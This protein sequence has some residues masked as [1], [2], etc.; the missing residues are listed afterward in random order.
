MFR[1]NSQFACCVALSAAIALGQDATAER[2]SAPLTIQTAVELAGRNYPAIRASLA[3]VAAAQSGVDLAKTAYLPRTD[4]RLGVNRA[5]RNNV[6][7]LILPNAVIPA[8]SG[9]VQDDATITSTFGSSAGVLFSYEPFDFGLRRSNV[10]VA[11][12]LQARAEAGRAVTEYEISL[13][14]AD[15]YLQAAA[16]QRAVAAAEATVDRMQ[17]FDDTVDVLVKNELR[18][19]AD[20]SRARAELVRARSELIR[21][22]EEAAK[23][24]ATL[25]QW[26]GVAGETVAI[27]VAGLAGDPPL[28][29]GEAGSVESHP[30]MAAQDAE[31]AVTDA[32]RAALEKEWRPTFQL[33]SALYGRGTGA[34]IDG[35]FQ[36]GAH[37]LAPSEGN[38]AVGFNMNFDLLDYKQSRVKRQIE[39]HHLERE[40]VRK[41]AVIQELRGEVARARIAVDA[42]IKIA[43][44]TPIELDAVRTLETQA[45]ARYNAK[46]ATVIEV[47]DAQR[48]LRQAEVDNFLARLG[49]WRALFAQAAAQGNMDEV[50]TAASR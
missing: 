44:N 14:A 36:G 16:T 35:T 26:L 25:A 34:R 24:L 46:L 1:L 23:S 31:I 10:Q 39:A 28:G 2:P 41:D 20:S 33:Q 38:W 29:V 22:E 45:Q 4:L 49:V 19:G 6:F 12:A 3:E 13:A 18:P 11:E 37:G 30:L 47:A 42:A 15:A 7:G 27:E 48:L 21:A 17:I 32:R 40:Q 8:I 5:T 9:P 50:L 43:A